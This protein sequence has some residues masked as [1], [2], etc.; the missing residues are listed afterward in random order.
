MKVKSVTVKVCK[1]IILSLILTSLIVNTWWL[2]LRNV[3]FSWE[4][5]LGEK[6]NYR[7]PLEE[8][9]DIKGG[10]EKYRAGIQC[11]A[12]RNITDFVQKPQTTLHL[13]IASDHRI[14]NQNHFHTSKMIVW[15]CWTNLLNRQILF[16]LLFIDYLEILYAIH[17]S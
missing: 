8:G 2:F 11:S 9:C 5:L 7:V 6:D 15:L 1:Y 3:K 12:L 13:K 16:M 17:T 14:I 4:F 10:R